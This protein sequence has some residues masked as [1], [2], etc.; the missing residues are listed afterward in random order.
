M[1]REL[2]SVCRFGAQ[3]EPVAESGSHFFEGVRK[4]ETWKTGKRILYGEGK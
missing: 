4:M 2:L 3:T 1:K